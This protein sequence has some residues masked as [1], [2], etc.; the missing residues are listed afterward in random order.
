[1]A[2][3]Y[4]NSMN[5]TGTIATDQPTGTN[6]GASTSGAGASASNNSR[7]VLGH[8]SAQGSSG[9]TSS[10]SSAS[11]TAP[12]TSFQIYQEEGS[13]STGSTGTGSTSEND[14]PVGLLPGTHKAAVKIIENSNWKSLGSVSARTKENDGM[15]IYLCC[16]SV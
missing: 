6:S 10:A 2:R 14:C 5:E 4:L 9:S 13:G 11:N 15:C 1:M 8:I 16:V 7:K 3:R 12:T